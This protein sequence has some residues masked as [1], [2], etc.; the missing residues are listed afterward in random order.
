MRGPF[1]TSV[2]MMN[3]VVHSAISDLT[4]MAPIVHHLAIIQTINTG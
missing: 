2:R 4:L 1:T 3:V